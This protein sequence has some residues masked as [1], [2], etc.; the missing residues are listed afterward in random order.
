MDARA[1]KKSSAQWAKAHFAA[2]SREMTLRESTRG[3]LR[4]KIWVR[5]VWQREPSDAR[6]RH[7]LLV[8]RQEQDGTFKHSLSNASRQT[9]P[10]RLACMQT[11]RFWIERAFQDAG[12]E[13]GMADYEVRGWKGWHH[14]MALVCLALLFTL[15][16]RIAHAQSIP[17][18]SVR[19]IVELL[20]IYLPPPLTRSRRSSRSHV[21]A[22]SNPEE[23]DQ[24]GAERA[25]KT[26]KEDNKVELGPLRMKAHHNCAQRSTTGCKSR[27]SAARVCTF[28]PKFQLGTQIAGE[29]I[30]PRRGVRRR[31][32]T[33][34][35]PADTPDMGNAIALRRHS[36]V[37]R[38]CENSSPPSGGAIGCQAM[39]FITGRDRSQTL[40]LPESLEDYVSEQ[41]RG[42]GTP[43]GSGAA[44]CGRDGATAR[45]AFGGSARPLA[46]RRSS[47]ASGRMKIPPRLDPRSGARVFSHSLATWERVFKGGKGRENIFALHGS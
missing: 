46:G 28:V 39:S 26:T 14:H 29:V 35:Q 9:S 47:L 13:L 36:Q 44:A 15:K 33:P 5:E 1:V 20:E 43:A 21:P 32:R 23:M 40:L 17:L 22:T 11:Q 41:H 18:L 19:D 34:I 6:A 2:E 37:Q 3:A 24:F 10:E 31:D 7:R 42:D 30:L 27:L 38:L 12:S 4:A 16:E 8:V 25:T 45:G